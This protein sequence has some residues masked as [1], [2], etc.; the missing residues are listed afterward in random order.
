MCDAVK[1]FHPSGMKDDEGKDIFDRTNEFQK[2]REEV[3]HGRLGIGLSHAEEFSE[4]MNADYVFCEGCYHVLHYG[5]GHGRK[6]F[7]ESIIGLCPDWAA[8][9]PKEA[10]AS[11][12][13][14]RP[15]SAWD[16]LE[17]AR[18]DQGAFKVAKEFHLNLLKTFIVGGPCGFGK[19]SMARA[20]ESDFKRD[21]MTTFFITCEEL[22][23]LFILSQPRAGEIDVEARQRLQEMKAAD[24]VVL[25]DLG[26]DGREYT[27]FFKE[28]LKLFLDQHGGRMVVTT[29]LSRE[30]LELKLNEKIASRIFARSQAVVL[31]GRNYRNT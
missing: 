30:A 4:A 31:R 3:F 29:N 27:E 1:A 7:G 13:K 21:D 28:K 16:D 18:I 6:S 24:L 20:I 22:V 9:N 10:A 11:K 23:E 14:Y 17:I 8:R 15:P 2:F 26:T 25:D 12:Y 19:T 5:A